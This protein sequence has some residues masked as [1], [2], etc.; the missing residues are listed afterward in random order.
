MGSDKQDIHV[1]HVVQANGVGDGGLPHSGST[2]VAH[3]EDVA[4]I[5]AYR[6]VGSTLILKGDA[7]KE[8]LERSPFAP[9]S[10]SPVLDTK[11]DWVSVPIVGG[12]ELKYGHVPEGSKTE[13]LLSNGGK[14][15]VRLL[16]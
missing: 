3:I 6:E 8:G 12:V 15:K 16:S 9:V 1:K 14:R 11:L 13:V 2:E 7:N 5:E 4:G 10:C